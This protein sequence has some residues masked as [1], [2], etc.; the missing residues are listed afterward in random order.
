MNKLKCL[1]IKYL[2]W[3]NENEHFTPE[4]MIQMILLWFNCFLLQQKNFG[5]KWSPISHNF[6]A[7]LPIFFFKAFTFSLTF[8]SYVQ[9]FFIKHIDRN[10]NIY[11]AKKVKSHS[12]FQFVMKQFDNVVW[13]THLTFLT[14]FKQNPFTSFFLK[15]EL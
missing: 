12:L 11:Y 6:L 4:V 2:N 8:S 5:W 14:K 10:V 9:S 15:E 13:R 1:E 3:K 7:L